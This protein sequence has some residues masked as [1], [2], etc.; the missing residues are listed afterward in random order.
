MDWRDEG[1][2]LASRP[3]GENAAI[4]EVFTEGH[5]RHLGIVQGGAGRSLAPALQPGNQLAVEWHA[6]LADHLG[7]FQVEPIASRTAAVI[8]DRRALMALSSACALLSFS[9]PERDPQP[10][11]YAAT[12]YLL[13]ALGRD[14]LWPGLYL[15]WERAL[16]EATGFGL[17]LSACAVTGATE[18]LAYVSPKSGRAVS[19]QGAG[20]WVARLLP[21]PPC[22][23]GAPP[24]ST[25]ELVEGLTTT[26]HFLERRLAPALG[27]RPLPA[28]RRRFVDLLA[29]ETRR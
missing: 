9:L 3:H 26:G 25:A 6:R 23:T 13:D 15:L 1:A 21:L 28:A 19:R 5:G 10:E 17:D 29:R 24:R 8:D 12:Q 2:V 14:P 18:D 22:L 27:H 7:R 4:V 16:L 11:L 20:N